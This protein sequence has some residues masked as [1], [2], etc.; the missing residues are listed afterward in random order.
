MYTGH[1]NLSGRP[2]RLGPDSRFFF[3]SS[4][5]EKALAYLTFGLNQ[6][7]GFIVVTGDVGTGKTTL[8]DYLFGQLDPAKFIAARVET[9]QL[10]A[11]NFLRMVASG[12]GLDQ[13]GANKATLLNDVKDFLVEKCRLGKRVLLVVDEVQ[14]LPSHSLEELR[15]LS[16]FRLGERPVLQVYLVGQPQ[17]RQTLAGKSM[18]QLRQRVIASHHLRPLDAGQTRGY[19]EHRLGLVGWQD[20]P[21]FTAGAYRHIYGDTGGVPRRINLLCER[22]L[23]FGSL[24]DLHEIDEAVVEEVAGDLLSETGAKTK[25]VHRAAKA[26]TKR[27]KAPTTSEFAALAKRVA[28]LEARLDARERMLSEAGDQLSLA[29]F[30]DVHGGDGAKSRG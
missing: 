13:E 16:N 4:S 22:L 1:Y 10:D 11:D 3:S 25:A 20:D 28:E 2:F 5:H 14:N 9:T 7:D 26:K 18:E 6:E 15:M 23:L 24:E 8:I 12:F 29:V 30:R 27:A 21:A 19:I 17:F